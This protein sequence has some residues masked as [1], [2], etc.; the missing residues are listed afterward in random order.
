MNNCTVKYIYIYINIYT[1][2]IYFVI[3][4]SVTI[5]NTPM[6]I[7]IFI[8]SRSTDFSSEVNYINHRSNTEY[9]NVTYQNHSLQI[10]TK[11]IQQAQ[12][13]INKDGTE[14]ERIVNECEHSH[15]FWSYCFLYVLRPGFIFTEFN[16]TTKL[17]T[18]YIYIL[19]KIFLNSC[20]YM[21][22]ELIN[23]HKMRGTS[24]ITITNIYV[25]TLLCEIS[26]LTLAR[27]IVYHS[28]SYW[29]KNNVE[30]KFST[31]LK[32]TPFFS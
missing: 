16:H 4:L 24:Y 23:F 10:C 11:L 3:F 30:S 15:R 32:S 6:S 13:R 17:L 27:R 14:A 18:S 1:P 29:H 7:I 25:T 8:I 31:V 26:H 22:I 5:Y 21:Y 20:N 9:C 19:H 12:K 2:H 28:A